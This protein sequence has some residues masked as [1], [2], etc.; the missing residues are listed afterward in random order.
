MIPPDKTSRAKLTSR[1]FTLLELMVTLVVFALVVAAVVVVVMNVGR[2]REAT[3]QR[4]ESEQTARAVL[5]FMTRDIRSAGYGADQSFPG[6][7]QPAVAYVDSAEIILCEN[8]AP[9]PDT[10]SALRLAPQAYDPDGSPKPVTLDG[11][12]W[13]PPTKYQTGAELVRYTLDVNNDGSVDADDIASAQGADAAMTP[14]PNDYVL[15]RE[16]YGDSTNNTSGNNGGAQERVALVSKPGGS[17]PPLFTVYLRGSS[18]P[19]NWANGPVPASQLQDIERIELN[20]TVAAGHP[21]AKRQYPSTTLSTQINA[22]RSTPDWGA[23]TYAV[24]GFVYDDQN[25]NRTM[26]TGDVGLAGATVRL[27]SYI[28]YTSA[29]GYFSIRVPN[30]TYGIRHTPPSGFGVYSNPDSFSVTVASA[31]VTASFAD[32]AR[33]GG[34][35]TVHVYEDEDGNGAQDAGEANLSGIECELDPGD[36]AGYTDINGNV[37]LFAPA[38]TYQLHCDV[39]DSMIATTANPVSGSMTNGGTASASFGLQASSNGTIRGQVFRDNN[40]N[41]VADGG[42]AGLGNVWVGVT[43][44]GGI[45]VQ[46]YSYTDA[47]GN[48]SIVVPANDPPHT[49]EYSAFIVPPAGFF[50]TSSTSIAGLWLQ[51]NH[52]LSNKNFGMSSYQIITLAA[53]RVL[54]LAAGDLIEADWT[55]NKTNEARR[56]ADLILGAD[57]GGTENIS[58][59]FNQYA[60]SALFTSTPTRTWAAPNAVMAMSVDTL[61]KNDNKLRPDLVTGTKNAANGNF[62][63]WL[64]QGS[65]NNEGYFPSSYSAGLNYRTSDAGDVQAV[66]TYDCAGGAMPDIIVGSKSTVSGR[67]S[68][69]VWQNSDATT[70]TFTRQ[71]IYPVA[72]GV[73]GSSMGEVTSMALADFDGDGV[74]DLVVGT[75]TGPYMG[76]VMFFKCA[77]RVNGNRFIWKN[78]ISSLDGAVTSLAVTDMNGDGKPDLVFGTQKNTSQGQL[79]YLRNYS[80]PTYWY[81]SHDR[82][83][84]A[85]GIV[86]SLTATDMGATSSITDLVVGWR[87]AE[88]S[89]GGGVSIYYLDVRTLPNNGVDPSNGAIVNM[90]PASTFANFNYGL[91]TTSPPSPYLNDLA[92]AV[93]SG[94]ATGLLVIF[95]R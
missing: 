65:K 22:L 79:K 38:T 46:G 68:V 57:A 13:E 28:G 40:R 26:D 48:Y 30:G 71:E 24:S 66:L 8:L 83:V 21:D 91:N 78:T 18:T 55:G 23:A 61:D 52:V 51:A 19:W 25:R 6:T 5:D 88:G 7:P 47:S 29:A 43:T 92:V 62:F 2:S 77:G 27:G 10:V 56:D 60:A 14:N 36:L 17:V 54:S 34:W 1:G 94:A 72:G 70:P 80:V 45:T 64:T 44:D 15:V 11:T 39:P 67:G 16:V 41:G 84:D 50:P 33:Q 31:P 4:M 35:V 85:P 76:E 9:W 3:A 90:V 73:P 89:Y 82:T 63:V 95:I 58:V 74:R 75:K 37:R 59:W 87:T 32:T 86:M 49:Q 69:E 81:F 53:S 20:V 12:T 42:E 93:K